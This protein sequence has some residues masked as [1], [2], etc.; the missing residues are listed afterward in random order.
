MNVERTIAPGHIEGFLAGCPFCTAK[1]KAAPEV[2]VRFRVLTGMFAGR[3]GTVIKVAEKYSL[4]PYEI[5]THL[6]GYEPNIQT[7]IL[8]NHPD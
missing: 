6:D 4:D 5:F 1:R 8:I 2:G 7:R 3:A